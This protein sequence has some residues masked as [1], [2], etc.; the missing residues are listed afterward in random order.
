MT[1][2]RR[3]ELAADARASTPDDV[4]HPPVDATGTPRELAPTP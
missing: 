1:T 2:D 3:L 4:T